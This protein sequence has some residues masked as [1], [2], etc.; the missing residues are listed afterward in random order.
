MVSESEILRLPVYG[1]VPA[2]RP[3]SWAP[4]EAI[5]FYPI[6]R[7]ALKGN[8]KNGFLLTV[9]GNSMAPDLEEG[10]MIVVN[11][12]LTPMRGEKVVARVDDGFTVKLWTGDPKRLAPLNQEH[13]EVCCV[14]EGQL[15]GVV[16]IEM[17]VSRVR[18]IK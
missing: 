11:P 10:D 8:P 14:E 6:P 3:E 16:V 13:K 2:G 9:R 5:D 12:N 15:V 18:K 4:Q 1:D 7:R 17:K